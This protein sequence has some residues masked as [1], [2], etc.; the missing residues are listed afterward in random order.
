MTIHQRRASDRVPRFGSMQG[1]VRASEVLE[2]CDHIGVL[3]AEMPEIPNHLM[4]A[5]LLT[6]ATKHPLRTELA[7]AMIVQLVEAMRRRPMSG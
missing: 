1:S 6:S 3:L 2:I 7:R 4:V 5:R